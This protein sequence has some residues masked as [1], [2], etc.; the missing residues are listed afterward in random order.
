MST[1]WSNKDGL[2][3]HFGT[4]DTVTDEPRARKTSTAGEVQELKLHITGENLGDTLTATDVAGAAFIPAQSLI[5]SAYLIVDE[6]FTSGGSAVLD[7]GT[8]TAAGAAIDDDGIDAAIAV[9]SLVDNFVVDPCDGALVG[10]V[11]TADSYLG[12]TYDTAAFT[13]GHATLVVT[14]VKNAV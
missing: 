9:A 5:K 14:F 4:R 7:L 13:A 11:V 12:A 3:V 2:A 10:T 8:Y 1:I 6:A